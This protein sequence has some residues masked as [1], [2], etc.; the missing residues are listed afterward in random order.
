MEQ[1]PPG[2]VIWAKSEQRSPDEGCRCGGV[3]VWELGQ[4]RVVPCTSPLS[5]FH[6]DNQRPRTS[7]LSSVASEQDA[8]VARRIFACDSCVF[9]KQLK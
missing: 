1:T 3:G 4:V 9:N 7:L 2:S 8:S 6:L 5:N